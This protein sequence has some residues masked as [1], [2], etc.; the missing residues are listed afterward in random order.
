MS[1]Q[2]GAGLARAMMGVLG[3]EGG[4]LRLALSVSLALCIA[5]WLG[6]PLRRRVWRVP[7]LRAALQAS[8]I[9]VGGALIAARFG[10]QAWHARAAWPSERWWI[11]ATPQ[12]RESEVFAWTAAAWLA[13]WLALYI[14]ARVRGSRAQNT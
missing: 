11:F 5:W 4:Q 1:A 6:A 12:Q 13:V 10:G 9:W 14:H 2:L 3:R 7:V 8:W